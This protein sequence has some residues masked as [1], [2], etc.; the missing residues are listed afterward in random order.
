MNLDRVT[1]AQRRSGRFCAWAPALAIVVL[2]GACTS[3]TTPNAGGGGPAPTVASSV[4]LVNALNV[5]CPAA[6]T[7]TCLTVGNISTISGIVPGLFEGAAVGTDA[8]FSYLDSTQGG[9]DGRKIELI[10]Q[11]DKFSG[12]ENSSETQAL[13]GRVL[14][15]VGSFS[16]EDQDGGLILAKHPTIPNV[17]LSLSQYTLGL[18]NTV[19]PVPAIGGWQLGGL[20]YFAHQYPNAIKHVGLL[21]AQESS[22]EYQALG[23]EAAM[24]HLGYKIVYSTLFGPLDTQFETQLVAMQHAGVQFVDLTL[25]DGADAEHIVDEMHQL[26][27]HPQVIESAGPIYVDN[28]VQL[29][30]GASNAD[31]IYLDQTDALY[32]GGDAKSVPEVNTFLSWVEKVHPG[33]TPDLFTLYGWISGML[34]A[35]GL[36]NAGANP[37]SAALLRSLKRVHSFDADGLIAPDNPGG[38]Q[39]PSCWLL[40]RIENGVFERVSPSPKTGFICDAPYYKG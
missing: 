9:I 18:P 32:L 21:I 5:N 3:H 29:S 4:R 7:A 31:G 38:R 27:Y 26:G 33:F 13:I 37:T 25:M 23:F 30:G 11:D 35:E 2:T 36:D 6:V 39:P 14:A 17:S 1:K 15:F 16:L 24:K 8:Y 34:F 19:S 10:S 28:F 12:Q 22:A 20:E 40:A